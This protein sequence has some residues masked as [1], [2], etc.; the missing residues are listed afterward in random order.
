MPSPSKPP[1]AKSKKP[2][3]SA[4]SI[5][6]S[7]PPPVDDAQSG[8][9]EGKGA[10]RL[11]AIPWTQEDDLHLL[12][13][14][15]KYGY[16]HWALISRE[17]QL[18]PGRT[19]LQLKNR[20]KHGRDGC[21]TV[22]PEIIQGFIDAFEL[23]Y[24]KDTKPRVKKISSKSGKAKNK[25]KRSRITSDESSDSYEEPEEEYSDFDNQN[26]PKEDDAFEKLNFGKELSSPQFHSTFS[27]ISG[28]PNILQ[29]FSCQHDELLMPDENAEN[30]FPAASAIVSLDQIS[31]KE[32]MTNAEFF[33]ESNP[34][35]SHLYLLV[36]NEITKLWSMQMPIHLSLKECKAALKQVGCQDQ[37]SIATVYNYLDNAQL[38]N[39]IPGQQPV[40]DLIHTT[41]KKNKPAAKKP[42]EC[43]SKNQGKIAKPQKTKPSLARRKQ[44][45]VVN[46]EKEHLYDDD[47]HFTSLGHDQFSLVTLKDC[48]PRKIYFH[49]EMSSDQLALIDFHAHLMHTE[50]IGLLGG[51]FNSE[52]GL[53][54]ISSSF[55]CKSI[56]TGTECEMDPMSE[57]EA[58]NYFSKLGLGIVGWYHSHP[59]FQPDPSIRDLDTQWSYQQLITDQG[60]VKRPFV[61]LI[62]SPYHKATC[63]KPPY[64]STYRLF[65]LVNEL[66]ETVMRQQKAVKCPLTLREVP[67]NIL[68]FASV[69]EKCNSQG[70]SVNLMES[71]ES[72]LSSNIMRI[73]KMKLS[74]QQF[75]TDSGNLQ[76]V[77]DFVEDLK[78]KL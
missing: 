7:S 66:D 27:P 2:T 42:K 44:N 50:I 18:T 40:A 1:S 64:H 67:P 13:S 77:G 33:G 5:L 34:E 55:A 12:E 24:G 52:T 75:F 9:K 71:L 15:Q 11:P 23:R 3:E 26:D 22:N 58:T 8:K 69:L 60:T 16:G 54:T 72:D 38:I 78:L 31:L 28:A 70:H 53:L 45:G 68:E 76:L 30:I 46:D 35:K 48:I 56:S 65:W 21:S 19:P 43:A 51:S 47:Y 41:D 73:D 57:L 39:C 10:P 62:V 49:V 36:R 74:L 63:L 14:I 4:G 32:K 37:V 6:H 20:T 61:G 25:G 17:W 59:T 29:L